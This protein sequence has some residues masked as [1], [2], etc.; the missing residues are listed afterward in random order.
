[1]ERILIAEL[2]RGLA[3]PMQ[4]ELRSSGYLTAQT[5]SPARACEL[6]SEEKVD[7]MIVVGEAS[8]R[9]TEGLEA[10]D[11]PPG[12]HSQGVG[13]RVADAYQFCRMLKSDPQGKT[14]PI[15]LV[16]SAWEEAALARGLESG[17]DYFLFAPFQ[18]QE[19]LQC[20]QVAL[21]N[22]ASGDPVGEDAGIEVFPQDH[23]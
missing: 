22:G 7:M 16:T 9:V 15:L 3:A 8:S 18:P 21:L 23:I 19:L 11:A 20:V 14:I 12:L 13:Q 1:M 5:T 4:R 17:A 10:T 6:L 2:K